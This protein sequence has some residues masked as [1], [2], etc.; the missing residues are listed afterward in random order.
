[1]CSVS[2]CRTVNIWVSPLSSEDCFFSVSAVFMSLEFSLSFF[3]FFFKNSIMFP[4]H[5]HWVLRSVLPLYC[6]S[7]YPLVSFPAIDKDL[8]ITHLDSNKS[9]LTDALVSSPV[10][11]SNPLEALWSIHVQFSLFHFT[12]YSCSMAPDPFQVKNKLLSMASKP[13]ISH[14]SSLSNSNLSLLPNAIL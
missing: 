4:F 11:L 10:P 13:F 1:M 3:F 14:P 2:F 5:I 9:L 7:F 8:L 6:L 12:S